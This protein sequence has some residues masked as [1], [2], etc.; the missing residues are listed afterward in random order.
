MAFQK[1]LHKDGPKD[2]E[3]VDDD[4]GHRLTSGPYDMNDTEDPSSEQQEDSA[5]MMMSSPQWP[6]ESPTNHHHHQDSTATQGP[7]RHSPRPSVAN[8][9]PRDNDNSCRV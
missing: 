5:T 2:G 9:M 7:V 1:L 6:A 4:T 8:T 3:P